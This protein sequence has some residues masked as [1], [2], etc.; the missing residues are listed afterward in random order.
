MRT[1]LTISHTTATDAAVSNVS[2]AIA[3]AMQ[4]TV[5]TIEQSQLAT[6]DQI[7]DDTDAALL[8]V[9]LDTASAIQSYLNALRSLRIPYL[10]VKSNHTAF[11]PKTILLPVTFLLE[12]REKG[13]Y[14]ASFATHFAANIKMIKPNDYGSKAQNNIDTLSTLFTTRNANYSIVP[15]KADSI[16]VEHNALKF[17]VSPDTEMLIIAASRDYGLDDIL[18]G[19]HER[20]TIRQ[21]TMPVLVVNPRGDLYPL[22]D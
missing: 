18:F 14:A 22:C 6:I 12:D 3:N 9:G 15:S 16:K 11:A 4:L 2:L 17:S 5:T 19:P 13:P 1:I 8:I 10:F 7:V 20:K 21:A